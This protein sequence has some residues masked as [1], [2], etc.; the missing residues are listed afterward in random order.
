M[1]GECESNRTMRCDDADEF[2]GN[3]WWVQA[4]D[5]FGMRSA[6]P[7]ECAAE[8]KRLRSALDKAEHEIWRMRRF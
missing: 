3:I 1:S 8:I 4:H 5:A 2:Y 6:S 7:G